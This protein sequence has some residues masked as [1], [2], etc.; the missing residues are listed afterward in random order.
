MNAGWMLSY[1]KKFLCA[2]IMYADKGNEFYESVS[3]SR[4]Q[5]PSSKNFIFLINIHANEGVW[6]YQSI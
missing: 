2:K 4:L 1:L 5:P 6:F 3:G